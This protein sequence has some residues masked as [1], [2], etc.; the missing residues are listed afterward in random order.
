MDLSSLAG[1]AESMLG[2]NGGIKVQIIGADVP[3]SIENTIRQTIADKGLKIE[4]ENITD[5][6]KISS[7]GVSETPAIAINGN[8]IASGAALEK[9]VMGALEGF[10]K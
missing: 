4:I 1:M 3:D 10:L 5:E 6:A 7:M 8:V 2:G 9:E